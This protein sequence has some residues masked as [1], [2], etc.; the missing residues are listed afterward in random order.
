VRVVPNIQVLITD[1]GTM[2]FEGYCE[3]IKLQMR[4]YHSKT[5]MFSIEMGGCNIVLGVEWW[6]KCFPITMEF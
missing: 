1:G 2:K 3:N 5:E 6:H 4:D